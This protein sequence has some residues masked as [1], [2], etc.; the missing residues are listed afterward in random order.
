MIA[1]AVGGIAQIIVMYLLI[2]N[3]PFL[4]GTEELGVILIPVYV[5]IVFIVGICYGVY[6][7]K[8][9]PNRYQRIG[10]VYDEE[11]IEELAESKAG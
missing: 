1:P 4:A 3:L 10:T 9:H 5:A 7:R 6:L 11:E 2:T 8:S